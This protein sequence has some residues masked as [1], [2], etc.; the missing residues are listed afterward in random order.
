MNRNVRNGK[1]SRSKVKGSRSKVQGSRPKCLKLD[2]EPLTLNLSPDRAWAAF[3]REPGRQEPRNRLIEIYYPLVKLHARQVAARLRHLVEFD[4]LA[5]AGV[6]GLIDAIEA[7]DPVR[8]VKFETFSALRIR[9]AMLDEIRRTDWISRGIRA[10][11]K[12]FHAAVERLTQ[13]FGR[14]PTEA[15]AGDELGLDPAE[16]TEFARAA[17]AAAL[18]SLDS[19]IIDKQGK[20]TSLRDILV[21][22]NSD[23]AIVARRRDWMRL[24]DE[25][26]D[27][28]EQRLIWLYYYKNWPMAR[29]AAV[30]GVVETRIC[31]MHEKIIFR[32]RS[33]LAG[34][35][36]KLE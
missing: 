22:K 24:V 17:Y 32:L 2:L 21:M 31:Q 1:G 13:Q 14:T 36:K 20:P 9:G 12:R 23:V 8:K 33:R 35:E 26:L 15:E 28:R 3:W 16:L 27:R 29:I 30:F 18:V 34:T 4:D 11:A 7:F 25:E 10:K 5:S 6:F 19:P